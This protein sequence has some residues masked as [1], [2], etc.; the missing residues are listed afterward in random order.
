MKHPKQQENGADKT[1]IFIFGKEA[2]EEEEAE[3]NN[4]C[5]EMNKGHKSLT[6]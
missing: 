3:R 5:E 6:Q 1:N 4:I 2:K